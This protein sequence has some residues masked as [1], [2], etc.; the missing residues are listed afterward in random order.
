MRQV[1][2]YIPIKVC[3]SGSLSAAQLDELGDALIRAIAA[4]M[5]QARRTLSEH[6]HA[7]TRET[8]AS[9]HEWFDPTRLSNGRY[10]LPSYD[11]GGKAVTV[12]VTGDIEAQLEIELANLTKS[13]DD[14]SNDVGVSFDERAYARRV[15]ILLNFGPDSPSKTKSDLKKFIDRCEMLAHGEEDTLDE[16]E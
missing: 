11:E 10:G 6:G 1:N 7:P 13:W 3:I 2:C 9:T 5:E 4:R 12:P 8:A 16:A 15:F 14:Y